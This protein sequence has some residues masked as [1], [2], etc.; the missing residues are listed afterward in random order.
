MSSSSSLAA[1]IV[2]IVTS[3]SVSSSTTTN[4]LPIHNKLP[5]AMTTAATAAASTTAPSSTSTLT[6]NVGGI[7][8]AG[9]GNY[10]DGVS[11]AGDRKKLIDRAEENPTGRSN[12]KN[13]WN[14]PA[15]YISNNDDSDGRDYN[16]VHVKSKNSHDF[17]KVRYESESRD[18]GVKLNNYKSKSYFNEAGPMA[19]G[20]RNRLAGK[21]TTSSLGRHNEDFS[22][23]SLV[24]HKPYSTAVDKMY[25]G[26]DVNENIADQSQNGYHFERSN[27]IGRSRGKDKGAIDQQPSEYNYF[28]EGG[29]GRRGPD[30][31]DMYVKELS[32]F[33]IKNHYNRED[34]DGGNNS[35]DNKVDG[36]GKKVLGDSVREEGEGGENYSRKS[37]KPFLKSK[38][39]ALKLFSSPASQFKHGRSKNSSSGINNDNNDDGDDNKNADERLTNQQRYSRPSSSSSSSSSSLYMHQSAEPRNGYFKKYY[40]DHYKRRDDDG[41][42]DASNVDDEEVASYN[43]RFVNPA[44]DY[45]L[46]DSRG[47]RYN[48]NNNRYFNDYNDYE[49]KLKYD[50]VYRDL[51]LDR[52][53]SYYN[54]KVGRQM[55]N[56]NDLNYFDLFYRGRDPSTEMLETTDHSKSTPRFSTGSPTELLPA[57]TAPA[58]LS[59]TAASKSADRKNKSS[60]VA[61]VGQR[62]VN[63]GSVSPPQ[64]ILELVNTHHRVHGTDNE[65][66]DNLKGGAIVALSLGIALTLLSLILLFCR[67]QSCKRL[68]RKNKAKNMSGD[69]DYLINGLYL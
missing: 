17:Q 55:K 57:T 21:A 51:L 31:D 65:S 50:P 11:E 9:S 63:T 27:Q 23:S 5:P 54:S 32:A 39:P 42:E 52:Y 16:G 30:M 20:D 49:T 1:S 14:Y 48:N 4:D 53:R 13:N 62:E 29:V 69:S 12:R 10:V 47:S 66:Y 28:N 22:R 33:K 40:R 34:A 26:Q 6:N 19:R 41:E 35:K 43:D 60:V 7:A 61:N 67:L 25:A 15:D 18:G 2:A 56:H 37:S 3:S 24:K 36:D 44:A 45:L 58:P 59:T 64:M 46:S 8:S 38:Q 68:S